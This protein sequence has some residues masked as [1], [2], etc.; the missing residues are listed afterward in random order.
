M[1]PTALAKLYERMLR[2]RFPSVA[3][4]PF[5]GNTLDVFHIPDAKLEVF[6]RYIMDDLATVVEKLHAPDVSLIPHCTSETMQYYPNIWAEIS[7]TVNAAPVEFARIES[8]APRSRC[9]ASNEYCAWA[10]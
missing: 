8:K 7:M 4:R 9:G 3:V 5:D 1:T 10:A 2:R 6:M